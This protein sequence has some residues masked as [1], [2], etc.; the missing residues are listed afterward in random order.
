VAST[1]EYRA[2][3]RMSATAVIIIKEERA[4]ETEVFSLRI[5]SRLA[6]EKRQP[7][8]TRRIS[9]RMLLA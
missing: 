2:V 9:D 3:G 6:E 7:P 5:G 8:K 1:V 4:P